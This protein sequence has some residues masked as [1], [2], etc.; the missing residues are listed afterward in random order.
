LV[1]ILTKLKLVCS[2]EKRENTFVLLVSKCEILI[3]FSV[4]CLH[5]NFCFAFCILTRHVSDSKLK[6]VRWQ[7]SRNVIENIFN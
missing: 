6:N 5:L 4:L 1:D 3:I 7:A 2:R